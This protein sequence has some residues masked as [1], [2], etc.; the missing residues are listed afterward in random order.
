VSTESTLLYQRNNEIATITLNR[1]ER[2]NALT[3]VMLDEL[4]HTLEEARD[5]E[6]VRALVITGAG[7]GFCAGQELAELDARM[8]IQR[9][10]TEH[11]QPVILHLSQLPKPVIAAVNGVAAGAGAA[12]ALACDLRVMAEDASLFSAFINIG[13]VPDAGITYFLARQVGYS[14][15]LEIAISGERLGAERALLLGLTNRVVP[16]TELLASA[17]AWATQL[18]QRPTL[19]IGLTKQLLHAALVHDLPTMLAQEA[20]QQAAAAATV[21]H[22]EGIAAF[23]EKRTPHFT[24]K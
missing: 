12:L 15:A 4:H 7:K 22:Q 14:R 9:H 21:D 24:G 10:L 8:D 5:D 18:A 1:P 20:I 19:A 2:R 11:Y 23:R 13:L 17:Q 3:S 6:R 16:A